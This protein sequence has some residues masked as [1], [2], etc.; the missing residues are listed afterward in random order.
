MEDH[1]ILDMFF[2]RQESAIAETR[3]KYGKRLFRASKNILHSNEDAEECVNDTLM[4]AWDAIPPNRPAIL[5]AFLAKIA[6][7]LSINK[8]EA[9]SAA[10]RGGGEVNLQLTELEECIEANDGRP[11]K[12]F[13]AAFVSQAIN[14]FLA[15]IDKTA[16]VAFVLRYF[17]GESVRSISEK[18]K[19]SESK[20]KSI[21]FRTRKKLKTHLEKEGV[22]V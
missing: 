13:E 5:G 2:A 18:F 6:R 17:H 15:D 9:K 10:K 16:R 3:Q 7:N 1:M 11:E 21:L 19:M 8:W 14:T 4:K 20:I 12:E 22:M